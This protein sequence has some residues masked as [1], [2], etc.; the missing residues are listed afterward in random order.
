MKKFWLW[1]LAVVITLGSAIY[2]RVTG[3]TYP[4]YGSVNFLHQQIKFKLPR[5]AENLKNCE[6]IVNLPEKLKG[7]TQGYLEFKKFKS[8]HPWNILTMT[9]QQEGLIGYLP[10]QP[11]AGK[12]EYYVHLVSNSQEI[13]LT[14]NNPVIIRF[15]GPVSRPVLIAHVLIMFL[16]MLFSVR[17]GLAAIS[18]KEDLTWLSQWTAIFFFLGGFIFGPIVQ[19]MAFGVFWSGFPLGHD[20]TDTKTLLIMI[21]WIAALASGRKTRPKRGWVL[22]ASIITLIIYFIPHSLWGS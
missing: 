13:S 18:R 3:P 12:L 4:F 1:L 20:L 21:A 22:A 7:V 11:P 8:D 15:K 6:I 16:A 17:A 14:G 5:S 19:K 10:K 2:Q 9:E